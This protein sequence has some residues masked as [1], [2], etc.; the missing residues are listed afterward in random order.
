MDPRN[1]DA[2]G[3]YGDVLL[4]EGKVDEAIDKYNFAISLDKNFPGPIYELGACYEKKG[5]K[6][7]AIETY[8]WYLNVDP[9]GR[10]SE[11]AH[12]KIKELS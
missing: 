12:K 6:A 11:S 8:Q 2:Y 5:M 4:T 7:K 9:Y 1:P 3:C 10:H